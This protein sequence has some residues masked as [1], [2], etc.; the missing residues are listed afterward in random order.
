[1]GTA[2]FFSFRTE[3]T[4]LQWSEY[5]SYLKKRFLPVLFG[6]L[7]FY[8]IIMAL[9]Y[10][11]LIPFIFILP[12]FYIKSATLGLSDA[13]KKLS[14]AYEF[15]SRHWAN[16]LIL[17]MVLS[18]AV[19]FLAQPFAFVIS[20]HDF[21]GQPAI[22][23]ILDWFTSF[24][25]GILAENTIYYTEIINLVRQ[26]VYLAF[27]V[28]VIPLFFISSGFIFYSARE[29]IDAKGLERDFEKFGK[30]SKTQETNFDYD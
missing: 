17:L 6:I 29:V 1:M 8:F 11:L 13:K 20:F 22:G 26:F 28:M 25:Q 4:K 12:F 3:K 10:Y 2:V 21:R 24:L 27:F 5:L 23:D 7:P 9:P 19:F 15:G 14:K 18:L 30:R 16:S